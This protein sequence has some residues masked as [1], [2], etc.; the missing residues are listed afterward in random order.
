MKQCGA[1]AIDVYREM[2]GHLIS[3][4]DLYERSPRKVRN[5]RFSGERDPT[6]FS[7]C[8]RLGMIL[9][10]MLLGPRTDR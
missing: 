5:A 9:E 7:F 6:S 2:V 3:R 1:F 10:E 4:A 8:N